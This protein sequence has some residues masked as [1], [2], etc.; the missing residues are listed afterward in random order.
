MIALKQSRS[1]NPDQ[2]LPRLNKFLR[3]VADAVFENDL[4]LVDVVNICSGI[5]FYDHQVSLFAN[6]DGADTGVLSE[7]PGAVQGGNL[8]R[9]DWRETGFDQQFDLTQIPKPRDNTTVARRVESGHQ[10][11]AGGDKRA[12]EVHRLP[13][14]GRCR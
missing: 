3:V 10:Q 14:Q 9:F 6:C 7:K 1:T 5:S 2:S 13:H 12:F 8:D 11:T 4:P